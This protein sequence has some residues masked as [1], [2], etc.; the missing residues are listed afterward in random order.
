MARPSPLCFDWAVAWLLS[1]LLQQEWYGVP[2]D[3]LCIVVSSLGAFLG[4]VAVH[5]L[6]NGRAYGRRA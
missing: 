6:G 5:F 3:D 4:V 1:L 2:L